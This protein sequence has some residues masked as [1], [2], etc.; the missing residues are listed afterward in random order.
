DALNVEVN[1]KQ[2]YYRML[3]KLREELMSVTIDKAHIR[4]LLL[5][6]EQLPELRGNCKRIKD[7]LKL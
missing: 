3:D 1:E 6:L 7:S 4:A 5:F 2:D